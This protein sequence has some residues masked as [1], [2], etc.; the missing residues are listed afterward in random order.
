VKSPRSLAQYGLDALLRA[1]AEKAQ[2]NLTL[3]EKHE[4]N[5]DS[6]EISLFR[7]TFDTKVGLIAIKD[8]RKGSTSIN[9]SDPGTIQEAARDVLAIAGASQPDEA[10]DIAEYQPPAEFSRGPETPDLNRMHSRLKDLI[11]TIGSRYPKVVIR[12]VYLEFFRSKTFLVNSNGVDFAGTK[13]VY[14]CAVIFSSREGEK[15]SSFN[16]TGFALKELDR[17]LIQGGS[18]DTLLRQSQ[19]QI[20]PKS[21]KGK[22][23]G[24]VIVT[25]DCLGDALGFLIS[26]ITDGPMISGTSIY[27]DSLNELVASPLLTLHSKPVSEEI[28][29]GYFFTSD[30]Y[31]AQNSTILDRGVLRTFLLSLYGAKKTGKDRAVNNGGA[32]VMEPGHTSLDE[33][34]KSVKKGILLARFSGGAP[35]MNGDFSG[36]AKNSY[37]IQDGEIAYPISETMISGN[38]AEMLKNAVAVS[39]QR[40]DFGDGI[41]PWVRFTGATISGK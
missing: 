5:V 32:W 37:L 27:K 3:S 17:D 14:R 26:S 40:V 33:M 6:G 20:S 23:V 34:V 16:Y 21:I 10:N 4:L 15:V 28:C 19:E 30:G 7:T 8:N 22:F 2:C 11:E 38:F 12:E 24:D 36:V 41:L 39:S 9:K 18:L 13:G 29:D 1:G 35:S 31:A 25:P